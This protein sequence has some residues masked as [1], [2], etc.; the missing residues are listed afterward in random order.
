MRSQFLSRDHRAGH[1]IDY[2]DRAVY[3]LSDLRIERSKSLNRFI[4]ERCVCT[5]ASSTSC[6][7]F[8]TNLMLTIASKLGASIINAQRI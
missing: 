8:L 7:S 2:E 3:D 6:E 4:S 5:N 1:N